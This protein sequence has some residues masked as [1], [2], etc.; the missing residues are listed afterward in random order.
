MRRL[1]ELYRGIQRHRAV[2]QL[3]DLPGRRRRS[4]ASPLP[5]GRHTSRTS[6]PGVLDAEHA[7]HA[8]TPQR[9]HHHHR[10]DQLSLCGVEQRKAMD[11]RGCDVDRFGRVR[12]QPRV[13]A[14]LEWL[15]GG[16]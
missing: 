4:Q 3:A 13:N 7:S 2:Q 12:R 15:R 8:V 1:L 6:L 14:S 11:P 5:G 10:P 16:Q 9:H